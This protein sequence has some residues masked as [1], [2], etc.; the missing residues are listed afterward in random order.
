MAALEAAILPASSQIWELAAHGL[1]C[2]QP[3]PCPR[4][5]HCSYNFVSTAIS[6][7]GELS[8]QA[9]NGQVTTPGAIP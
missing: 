4:P 2:R 1:L 9:M 5:R 3:I 7:S 6:E 8:K